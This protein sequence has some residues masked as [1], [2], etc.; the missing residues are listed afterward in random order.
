MPYIPTL[1][2]ILPQI[3]FN[4]KTSHPMNKM[5]T[6]LYAKQKIGPCNIVSM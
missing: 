4:L 2:I 3:A 5:S 6:D 1:R